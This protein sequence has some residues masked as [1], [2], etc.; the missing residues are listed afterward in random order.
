MCVLLGANVGLGLVVAHGP[1]GWLPILA[2]C[3]ATYAIF[4]LAG[5]PMRLVL[6]AC[7]FMWIVNNILSRSIG[8]TVLEIVIA[9]TNITT[10]A[11]AVRAGKPAAIRVV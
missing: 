3:C 4:R 2:T 1:A 5:V 6:L 7:T 8:G 10:I 9:T 11:R